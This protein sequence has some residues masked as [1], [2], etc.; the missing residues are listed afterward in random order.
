M[1]VIRTGAV[2]AAGSE[3]DLI[4]SIEQR[5]ANYQQVHENV[6]FYFLFFYSLINRAIVKLYEHLYYP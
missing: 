6:S 4:I 1:S 3:E 2:S 5:S